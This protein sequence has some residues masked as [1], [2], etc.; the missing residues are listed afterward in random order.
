MGQLR[1]RD[2]VVDDV[3]MECDADRAALCTKYGL[4]IGVTVT[5]NVTAEGEVADVLS[6]PE[7]TEGVR[8]LQMSIAEMNLFCC[9][10]QDEAIGNVSLLVR[11]T[12]APTQTCWGWEIKRRQPWKEKK[13]KVETRK[14]TGQFRSPP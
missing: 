13:G 7:T 11:T 9:E 1:E 5:V 3:V 8:G 2:D 14:H 4:C 12:T 10:K 6:G